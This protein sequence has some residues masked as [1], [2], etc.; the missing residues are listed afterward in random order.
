MNLD[1]ALMIEHVTDNISFIYF[2]PD[3]F[4]FFGGTG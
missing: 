1:T 2:F 4:L 3:F